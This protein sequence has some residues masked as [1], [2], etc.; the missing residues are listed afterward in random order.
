M[1]EVCATLLDIFP[2]RTLAGLENPPLRFGYE[3]L[4]GPGRPILDLVASSLI[5]PEA[6][7]DEVLRASSP[8]FRKISSSMGIR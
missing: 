8:Q 5:E 2:N 6:K 7:I 1:I 3:T 4:Q